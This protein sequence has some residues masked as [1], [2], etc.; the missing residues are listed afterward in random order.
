MIIHGPSPRPFPPP[1]ED[2]NLLQLIIPQT[3][4]LW[5]RESHSAWSVAHSVTTFFLPQLELLVETLDGH[6]RVLY[7]GLHGDPELF[8][9][10][11][12]KINEFIDLCLKLQ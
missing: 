4:P 1:S 2:G 6:E 11:T 10:K 8:S 3:E 9:I 7:G 12:K 5:N